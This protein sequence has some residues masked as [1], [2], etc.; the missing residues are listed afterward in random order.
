MNKFK[1]VKHK[2]FKKIKIT[3]SDNK[4]IESL[5]NQRKSLRN[6]TDLDSQNKLKD[7]ENALAEKLSEDLYGIIKSETSQI[8][9]EEGGFHS[10]HLWNLKNKLYK[11]ARDPPTAILDEHGQLVTSSLKIKS[12]TL[13]H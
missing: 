11:K 9:C 5:Y 3:K 7:I 12:A 2:C 10:G 8:N 1:N 6:K 4:E 13:Q